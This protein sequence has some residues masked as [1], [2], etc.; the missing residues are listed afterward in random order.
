[1]YYDKNGAILN[2]KE[3]SKKFADR[4][5]SQVA[6]T[7]LTDGKWISTV[8]LGLDYAFGGATPLFFETMVFSNYENLDELDTERYSTLEDATTG[9]QAMVDKWDN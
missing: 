4:E 6:T 2:P 7:T 1:M 8:W 9:H 3:W 5:Y